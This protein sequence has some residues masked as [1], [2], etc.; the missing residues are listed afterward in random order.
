MCGCRANIPR[1][2]FGERSTERERRRERRGR[3]TGNQYGY[4]R[5]LRLQLLVRRFFLFRPGFLLWLR[6]R[7]F[8]LLL[9]LRSPVEQPLTTYLQIK[10]FCCMQV[11]A[12][13]VAATPGLGAHGLRARG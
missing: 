1:V 9:W 5:V 11:T 12:S 3:D 7:V 8:G 4:W 10:E 6:T 13:K 2:H